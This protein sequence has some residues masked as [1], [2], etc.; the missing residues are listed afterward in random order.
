MDELQIIIAMIERQMYD[1]NLKADIGSTGEVFDEKVEEAKYQV[2]KDIL[3]F[4]KSLQKEPVSDDIAMRMK[5]MEVRDRLSSAITSEKENAHD[6]D[7]MEVRESV[8]KELNNR[9]L[10]EAIKHSERW[11]DFRGADA[12]KVSYSEFAFGAQWLYE[13][14]MKDA[15]QG[16][17]NAEYQDVVSVKSRAIAGEERKK[18]GLH[19]CAKIKLIIIKEG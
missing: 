11:K 16:F 4:V 12:M 13:Q 5:V 14:M 10:E 19:L 1:Y 3:S 6:V 18:L 9:I 7:L 15:V 8:P 17:I 2:C